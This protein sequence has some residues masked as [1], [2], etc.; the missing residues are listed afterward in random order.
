MIEIDEIRFVRDGQ[1]VGL[2]DVAYDL[3][4]LKAAREQLY[5]QMMGWV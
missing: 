2:K 1:I 4:N 5:A 3:Y